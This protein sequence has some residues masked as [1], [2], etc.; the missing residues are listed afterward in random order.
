MCVFGERKCIIMEFGK[1]LAPKPVSIA[2]PTVE[3]VVIP[4]P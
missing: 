3:T 2:A 4:G 1:L